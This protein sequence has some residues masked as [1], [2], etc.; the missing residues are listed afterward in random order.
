MPPEVYHSHSLNT[1]NTPLLPRVAPKSRFKQ[2]LHRKYCQ[3]EGG[4][5]KFTKR[6]LVPVLVFILC[7][8]SIFRFLNIS[9]VTS[10]FMS[11]SP[12]ALPPIHERECSSASSVCG[13][14]ISHPRP[15]SKG[16]SMSENAS[17]LTEKEMRFLL[18]F[19][20]HRV[21]CNLLVFGLEYQYSNIASMNAGGV[22]IF[23]EESSQKSS[24]IKSR[25][26]T[27][28]HK[29][30]Y[31]TL[32]SEAYKLLKDARENPDCLPK[33]YFPKASKCNLGLSNLPHE[34]YDTMWDVVIVDGPRGDRP[35]SPG[36]MASIYT[37]SIL[38][39]RGNTTHVVVH[40]VDRMIEKWFSQEFLC[41]EN[42]VSSK[43]RFQD[44]Q[45]P[46]VTNATTFCAP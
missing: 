35:D 25:N 22:T 31:S 34:V 18:E 20:S 13:H 43:G 7:G 23:L 5:M 39:R 1:P 16:R 24:V 26:N 46:G 4:R 10:S 17:S 28:V 21:P 3:G 37:A 19:L 44:F 42:L 38:A 12:A 9:M 45:I 33:I 2:I 41:E 32:A 36:R 27:Q 8:A 30:T 6:K 40:D 11:L 15:L 14:N 29:I